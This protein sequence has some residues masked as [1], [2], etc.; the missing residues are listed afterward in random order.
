[1]I[2][3]KAHCD[4]HPKHRRACDRC[5]DAQMER[6]MA[7]TFPE[8]IFAPWRERVAA[9]KQADGGEDRIHDDWEAQLRPMYGLSQPR[10]SI[11]R[12]GR[13]NGNR[14]SWQISFTGED[15]KRL[16]RDAELFDFMAHA[17]NED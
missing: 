17:W 2:E 10:Y 9:A 6:I 12:S 15:Q 1:M 14:D 7:E 13:S 8:V 4:E 11:V 16:L 3:P 5:N